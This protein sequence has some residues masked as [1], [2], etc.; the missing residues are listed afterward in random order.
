[1]AHCPSVLPALLIC[2]AVLSCPPVLKSLTDPLFPALLLDCCPQLSHWPTVLS[3]PFGYCPQL[4][5]WSTV[6]NCPTVLSGLFCPLSSAV[7]LVILSSAAP[8]L[9]AVLMAH[10]VLSCPTASCHQLYQC[11]TVHT[12]S[13]TFSLAHCPKLSHWPTLFNCPTASS[14]LTVISCRIGQLSS[15]VSSAPILSLYWPSILS[16]P[17]RKYTVKEGNRRVGRQIISP[18]FLSKLSLVPRK[19]VCYYQWWAKLQL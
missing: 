8:L 16:C 9:S 2:P 14:C 11:H 3:C 12:L 6:F 1:M 19:S 5:Y 10:S 18:K 17:Q 4:S 15:A 7:P 13:A